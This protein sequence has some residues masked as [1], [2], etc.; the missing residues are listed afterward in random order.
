MFWD[1][2]GIVPLLVPEARSGVLTALLRADAELVLWWASPLEC[3]SALHRQRREE[4]LPAGLLDAAFARLRALVE[5]ADFVAPSDRVR[6]RA[7]RLLAAYP[8]RAGDALQLAAALVWCDETPHGTGF[9]CLD[10]R[11]RHAARLEGFRLLPT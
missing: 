3:Q 9:V 7:G 4:A 2:S 1:S 10:D 6:E 11:L 8:L 5:D